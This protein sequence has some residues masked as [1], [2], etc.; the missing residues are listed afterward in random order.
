[1]L[2]SRE[3]AYFVGLDMRRAVVAFAILRDLEDAN[4]N[5]YL[6]RVAIS[7]TRRRRRFRVLAGARELGVPRDISASVLAQH[8]RQ[9]REG[10]TRL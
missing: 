8:F 5:L 6:K 7:R 9:Q 1:M 10:A 3:Y 2:A 4:G